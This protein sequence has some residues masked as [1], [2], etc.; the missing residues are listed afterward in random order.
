MS[1]STTLPKLAPR[2]ADSHKADFG[3]ALLIG[4][5]RGM[6]GAIALAGMATLRSGAG[7]VT[8]AV[9]DVIL[10]TVAG[11]EPSYMTSPLPCDQDG[12][13][14]VAAKDRISELAD[15]ATCL[16]CGPGL[17]RSP[18][19][20]DL[21]VWMYSVLPQPMV[22]DADALF[23]LSEHQEC[24]VE[25]AGPRI[26][27]PHPGEFRRL[28][29]GADLQRA[30]QESR[31]VELAKSCNA[32]ILLKGN[33]TLITDG[34][35]SVHNETGNPGMATG[36]TGDVL[37]G[38]ITALVCQGLSPMD[39]AILAAHVHG[40]AGDMAAAEL[41]Q[42]AMIASDLLRFLPAAFR[43]VGTEP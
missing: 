38:V 5:S 9:P 8:V 37:S 24:L 2:R 33:H 36:G 40:L 18:Q 39:A 28:I 10:D 22:V 25:P 12:H 27:T 43:K 16:T 6:S 26:L 34:E 42:V 29:G 14:T 35:R 17:G 13:L 7:L 31:A 3:R 30:E 20:V 1:A 41:G 32:V 4:G 15:H 19:V 11:F 23:A 21:V